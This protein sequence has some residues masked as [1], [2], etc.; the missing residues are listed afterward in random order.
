MSEPVSVQLGWRRMEMKDLAAVSML[1]SVCQPHPWGPANF[2]GELLRGESSFDRVLEDPKVGLVGYV[3]AWMVA[4]ELHIGNIGVDPEIRRKGLAR[5]MMSEAH[6]WARHRGAKFAH[7]EV[8]AGNAS[9]IALYES[10]GY[11]RVGVRKAYYA[12]N[13][14]DAHLLVADL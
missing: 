11:R 6:D 14:E 4:D 7:L 13:N 1:D 8:R 10:L 9:A 12:D 3:C 2:Q 5:G